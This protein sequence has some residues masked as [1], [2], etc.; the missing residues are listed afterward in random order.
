MKQ[1]QVVDKCTHCNLIEVN[2]SY[3]KVIFKR[4]SALA[5]ANKLQT[6]N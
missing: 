2:K 6:D 5:Y 3:K 4:I 1:N